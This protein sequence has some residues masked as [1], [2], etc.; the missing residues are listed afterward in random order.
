MNYAPHL[1]YICHQHQLACWLVIFAMFHRCNVVLPDVFHP[2]TPG[3]THTYR[4]QSFSVTES[5]DVTIMTYVVVAITYSHSITSPVFQQTMTS[6]I[7]ILYFKWTK[8]ICAIC[9]TIQT[10]SKHYL[11]LVL[12]YWTYFFPLKMPWWSSRS[13]ET[14]PLYDWHGAAG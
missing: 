2:A 5:C 11:S 12:H 3:H 7:P 8:I 10:G 6:W 13:E 14:P 4:H 9:G 1:T